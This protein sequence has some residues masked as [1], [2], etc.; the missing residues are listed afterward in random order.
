MFKVADIL[1]NYIPDDICNKI[2][3]S[4][5]CNVKGYLVYLAGLIN[6]SFNKC[7][8]PFIVFGLRQLLELITICTYVDTH[9]V[10][11]NCSLEEKL[12]LIQDFSF[13]HMISRSTYFKRIIIETFGAG[14]G[15]AF[16]NNMRCVYSNLSRYLHI[17]LSPCIV[18]PKFEDPCQCI[19]E[20][21]E[22]KNIANTIDNISRNLL[23][24]WLHRNSLTKQI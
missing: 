1:S 12:K 23:T 5:L 7:A 13:S 20:I 9:N 6:E 15:R 22:L 2:N 19:G 24:V 18:N 11:K 17:P 3:H 8:I 10:Y 4:L 14:E 21:K 16:I